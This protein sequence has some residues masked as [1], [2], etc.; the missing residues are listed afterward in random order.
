MKTDVKINMIIRD[1]C[2][3]KKLLMVLIKN[4]DLDSDSES[5]LD[6]IFNQSN[7]SESIDLESDDDILDWFRTWCDE[8]EFSLDGISLI[9]KLKQIRYFKKRLPD[10]LHPDR[11]LRSFLPEPKKKPKDDIDPDDEL[12]FGF[13]MER[14][15]RHVYLLTPEIIEE[16]KKLD[17]Q[18]GKSAMKPSEILKNSL[19]RKS[20]TALA[21]RYH[22]IP[23]D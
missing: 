15:E 21:M 3:I 12:F 23:E 1:L 14:V 20:Y 7:Q 8:N 2:V 5:E 10:L 4:Q 19:Y 9:P 18:L 6:L 16:V 17:P 22:L 11:Y 13:D